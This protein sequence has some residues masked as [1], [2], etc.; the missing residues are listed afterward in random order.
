MCLLYILFP[1][2]SLSQSRISY[3]YDAAGNRM[4]REIVIQDFQGSEAKR[5]A[6][7]TEEQSFSDMLG[8][9]S[10]KI[11]PTDGCLRISI[12]G[13]KVSDKIMYGVYTTQGAEITSGNIDTDNFIVDTSNRQT[14]VYLLKITINDNS[15]T[16]KIVKK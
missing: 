10:I 15:T 1:I 4:K 11:Y 2:A 6:F 14:G 9:R 12:T 3:T 13:M 7:D 5:Y 8:E 16:W